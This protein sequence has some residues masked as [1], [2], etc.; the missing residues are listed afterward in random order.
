MLEN[1]FFEECEGV[2]M[3]KVIIY[4]IDL[5]LFRIMNLGILGISIFFLI[6]YYI[7]I[8]L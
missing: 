4:F 1:L 8:Y 6:V 2:F 3:Y 7:C 5:V